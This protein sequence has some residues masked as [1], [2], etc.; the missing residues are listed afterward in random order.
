MTPSRSDI[1]INASKAGTLEFG[2]D[3]MLDTHTDTVI[4]YGVLSYTTYKAGMEYLTDDE[5]DELIMY[6]SG[7]DTKQA[8]RLLLWMQGK[9]DNATFLGEIEFNNIGLSNIGH[10]EEDNEEE[11][12]NCPLCQAEKGGYTS[13]FQVGDTT[14]IFNLTVKAPDAEHICAPKI[15]KKKQETSLGKYRFSKKG[16][17]GQPTKVLQQML[18][19]QE[20]L[21]EYERCSAIRDEINSRDTKKKDD[22]TI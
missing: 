8:E 3:G 9:E 2:R 4:P 1:F 5:Q 16:L 13:T 22:D 17:K 15:G 7:R 18:K 21:G 20:N 19:T 12:C 10:E 11:P 6:L 14:Y